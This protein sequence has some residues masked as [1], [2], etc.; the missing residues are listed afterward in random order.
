LA[1]SIHELTGQFNKNKQLASQARDARQVR[2]SNGS[3][4]I[5]K[6]RII[7][8]FLQVSQWIRADNDPTLGTPE[9]DHPV[10]RQKNIKRLLGHLADSTIFQ[11]YIDFHGHEACSILRRPK[12]HR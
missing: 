6:R 7:V 11:L 12:K 8:V 4:A 3:P 9:P 5:S 10:Q 2:L 1:N